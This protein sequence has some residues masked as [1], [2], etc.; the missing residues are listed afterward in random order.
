MEN[1]WIYDFSFRPLL[2][3]HDVAS[4]NWT[5]YLNDIGSF[6]LHLPIQDHVTSVLREH[7]YL[8]AVQGKKQAIITGWQLQDECVLYGRTCNWLLTRRVTPAFETKTDT[9][10]NLTRGFVSEAF[11]DVPELV[12]GEQAGMTQA[13]QFTLRNDRGCFDVVRECLE[14]GQA[15]HRLQFDVSEKRWVYQVLMGKELQLVLSEDN[16]NA[17]ESTY[18]EDF[19]DYYSGGWYQAEQPADSDGNVS[20]PVRTYLAGDEEKTGIYKWDCVLDGTTTE[21]AGRDLKKKVWNRNATAVMRD[22]TFGK[23]YDLGDWL[24]IKVDKG[25]LQFLEKKR[26]TGVHIWYE[27]ESSG[28]EPILSQEGE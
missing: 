6:E 24:Q 8:V 23:D 21:E 28:E 10:E 17:V 11:A 5:L 2:I 15:G 12:L 27:S 7:P 20:D 14:Q 26:V 3:I 9:A 13:I 4:V 22:V 25:G 19:L 16:R 1:I 18:S